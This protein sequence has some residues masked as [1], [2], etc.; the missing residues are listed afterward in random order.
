M[1]RRAVV[2]AAL[3]LL[4]GCSGTPAGDATAGTDASELSATE[5][6]TPEATEAPTATPVP[7]QNPWRAD[8]IVVGVADAEN[9]SEYVELVREATAYWETNGS[10]YGYE[11]NYAVRPNASDPDIVVEFAHEL[12]YCDDYDRHTVGCAPVL[13]ADSTPFGTST[14]SIE[15][16]YTDETTFSILKHEFG[17]TLGLTHEAGEELAFMNASI[18]TVLTPKPNATDRP[19]PWRD[20]NLTLYVDYSNVSDDERGTYEAEVAHAVD[21]YDGGADGYLPSNVTVTTVRNRSAA[22]VLVTFPDRPLATEDGRGTSWSY[23]FV[24]PD[25]DGSPE[26]YVEGRV[27]VVT[28]ETR[29]VDLYL[30][31][32]LGMLFAP[33]SRSDLPDPFDGEGRSPDDEWTSRRR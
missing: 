6:P 24:D 8:P 26:W 28:R 23:R 1:K 31:Y 9:D 14:V 22:D 27:A 29:H 25:E 10:A 32:G 33:D 13:D 21:Y 18:D 15:R 3:L 4:A 7:P 16:G 19:I 12:A 5:T 2:L 11:A 30:G 20:S 17:H